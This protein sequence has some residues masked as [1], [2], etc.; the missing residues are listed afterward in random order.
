MP[1]L[2]GRGGKILAPFLKRKKRGT[3]SNKREKV[4]A[5]FAEEEVPKHQ[6]EAIYLR[7]HIQD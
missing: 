7:H 4:P 1:S 5:L 6:K 3:T 2:V